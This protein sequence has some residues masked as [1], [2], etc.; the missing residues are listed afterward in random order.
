MPTRRPVL[1]SL[2][3]I[4][5]G[6]TRA[7]DKVTVKERKELADRIRINLLLS[8]TLRSTRPN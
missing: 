3:E 6:L 4:H 7:L 2:D 1:M 8:A 5:E